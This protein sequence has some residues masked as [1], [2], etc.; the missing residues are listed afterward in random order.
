MLVAT[1]NRIRLQTCLNSL[2][3]GGQVMHEEA[4]WSLA[5]C[6]CAVERWPTYLQVMPKMIPWMIKWLMVFLMENI[7]AKGCITL[8][9]FATVLDGTDI[10]SS[11]ND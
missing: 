4:C 2:A 11:S 1:E 10:T 7:Y 5:I 6:L 3:S 9:A 8:P